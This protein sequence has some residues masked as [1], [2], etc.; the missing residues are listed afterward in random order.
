MSWFRREDNKIESGEN[1]VRTEGLWIKCDGC[2]PAYLESRPR[3]QSAGVPQMR[4][5]HGRISA[6]ARIN[7][8]LE[9][10]YQ[11]LNGDL[12]TTDPLRSSSISGRTRTS[13]AKARKRHGFCSTRSSTS[14]G[15]WGRTKWC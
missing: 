14:K 2:K 10:G 9:P 3:D 13:W 11:W 6:Q 12:K 15:N 1:R 5:W 8:L 7:G 4:P